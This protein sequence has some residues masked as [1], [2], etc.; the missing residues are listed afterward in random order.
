VADLTGDLGELPLVV[1]LSLTSGKEPLASDDGPSA[2]L[3]R[4]VEAS[5]ASMRQ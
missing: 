3:G 4:I 5:S 1:P 2:D